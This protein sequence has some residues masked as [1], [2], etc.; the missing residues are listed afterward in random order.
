MGHINK[1]TVKHVLTRVTSRLNPPSFNISMAEEFSIHRIYNTGWSKSLSA[2]DNYS[3]N[4]SV[5]SNNFHIIDE[6]KMAIAEYVRNVDRAILNTIFKNTDR[7]VRLDCRT[8]SLQLGLCIRALCAPHWNSFLPSSPEALRTNRRERLLLAREGN[9]REFSQQ[10][11]IHRRSWGFLHAPKLG[12][13]DRLFYF[14]SEGG[15]AE[16]FSHRKKI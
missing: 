15:H 9:W 1:E 3:T 14:S 2:P 5:Y 16:D 4:S 12:T 6:L 7:R 8:G 13:W 10:P 11:V